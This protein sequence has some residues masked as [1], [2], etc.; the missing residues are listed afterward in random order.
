MQFDWNAESSFESLLIILAYFIALFIDSILYPKYKRSLVGRIA[1]LCFQLT[2]YSIFFIW[3]AIKFEY[4]MADPNESTM[5]IFG[6]YLIVATP[7]IIIFYEIISEILISLYNNI[8]QYLFR[9][10]LNP[11]ANI[12]IEEFKYLY[13]YHLKDIYTNKA[14][15]LRNKIYHAIYDALNVATDYIPSENL[16]DL[17]MNFGGWLNRQII[18]R[19]LN[20]SDT[21]KKR[22]KVI[23]VEYVGS[24]LNMIETKIHHVGINKSKLKAHIESSLYLYNQIVPDNIH[25]KSISPHRTNVFFVKAD[26]DD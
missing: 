23:D 18:G 7:F 10:K 20:Y 24:N 9:T 22:R 14:F 21:S 26:I 25:I 13:P 4:L 2:W 16:D 15:D 3:Y 8:W 1:T 5:L 6:Y 11:G 12:T 17:R 19:Y